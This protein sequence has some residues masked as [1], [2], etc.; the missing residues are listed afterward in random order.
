VADI[1]DIMAAKDK[2]DKTINHQPSKQQH[3]LKLQGY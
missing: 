3:L 1:E 2:N